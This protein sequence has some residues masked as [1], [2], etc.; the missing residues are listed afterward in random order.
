MRDRERLELLDAIG[1]QVDGRRRFG[2]RLLESRRLG[3]LVVEGFREVRRGRE[4]LG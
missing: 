4:L 1:Q 2:D 3:A